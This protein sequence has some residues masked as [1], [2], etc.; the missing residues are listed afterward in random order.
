MPE[1]RSRA[2][3]ST[4]NVGDGLCLCKAIT[5]ENG[6]RRNLMPPVIESEDPKGKFEDEGAVDSGYSAGTGFQPTPMTNN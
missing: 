3:E 5:I 1:G 6:V 4:G 2:M